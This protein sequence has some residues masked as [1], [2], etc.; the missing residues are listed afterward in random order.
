[1]RKLFARF[2]V[3]MVLIAGSFV[4]GMACTRLLIDF[5]DISDRL[6]RYVGPIV[7]M[8]VAYYCSRNVDNL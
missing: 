6:A 7:F 1:M 5:T 8:I 2:V 4:I 3:S